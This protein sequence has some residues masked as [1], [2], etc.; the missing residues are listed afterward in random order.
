MAGVGGIGF[1]DGCAGGTPLPRQR[2]TGPGARVA[3]HELEPGVRELLWLL[4]SSEMLSMLSSSSC[5]MSAVSTHT[6]YVVS[7]TGHHCTWLSG[8]IDILQVG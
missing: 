8:P 6:D 3:Q 7:D 2:A 4:N 1:R 5:A